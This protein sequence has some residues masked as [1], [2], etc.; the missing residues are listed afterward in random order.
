M[1]PKAEMFAPIERIVNKY[2]SDVNL[3]APAASPTALS[4][5]EDH[6]GR[7]LP[8]GLRDFLTR[9]NGATL[10][11]GA[12]R[13]RNASEFAA[14]NEASPQITL[15]AEGQ[16]NKQWA[17]ASDA[18]GHHVFGLWDG[19]R[20]RPMHATFKGWLA[21]TIAV[22]ET[23]VTREGD[24][25]SLRFA[26]D[27]S[28]IY[29]KMLEGE[30]HLA[31]GQADRAE[32]F[33][34]SA[35]HHPEGVVC[36]WQRLGDALAA[37]DRSAARKA[38]LTSFKN[39]RL[40]L[41]WPGAPCVE[42]HVFRSL[43]DAFSNVEDYERVLRRF[44]T[45]QVRDVTSETEAQLVFDAARTL[46]ASLLKRGHRGDAREVLSNL[47]GRTRSFSW[48]STPWRASVELAQLELELG[49]HD[50]AEALLRRLR[51]EGPHELQGKGLLLLAQIAIT[52]Q[53]PWAEEILADARRAGVQ[54]E[55]QV[56]LATLRVER[57]LR[58]ERIEEARKW[59]QVAKMEV[60]KLGKP[61]FEARVNLAEGDLARSSTEYEEALKHYRHGLSLLEMTDH[62]ETRFRLHL[63]IGDILQAQR[64]IPAAR[65]E[66]KI[67]VDGFGHNELPVREGWALVR[68][69]RLSE[70]PEPLLQA[71]KH[72]FERSDLAAGIAAVDTVAG[73]PGHSLDWHLNRATAQARARY[74]AQRSKPPW[75]RRDA[76]RPERRLGAHRLAIAACAESIV[77][78]LAQELDSCARAMGTGRTRPTDPP[79]MRYIAAVDLVAGHKSYS[80]AKLLLDHLVNQSVKGP[81]RRA[82]Q[83]AVARSPNA[84][85][86]DGLLRCI[87]NPSNYPAP[88]VAEA[89]EALGLRREIHATAA[90]L[91][92][93]APTGH[94]MSRKAAITALGRIGDRANVDLIADALSAPALEEAAALSLLML[95]DRRG[96]DFHA[97]ALTEHR[98]GLSGSPGE[99]VGRYGGP[100]H[101][102]LLRN[103]ANGADDGA[104]GAILG[105]GLLGDSRAIP[106]LLKALEH[107]DRKVSDVANGALQIITGHEEEMDQPGWK[108]RWNLWWEKH[109]QT[110]RPGV[111]YRNGVVYD[112]G[113]L[114][115]NMEH[116]DPWVRRT[117]YDELVITTGHAL[118][119][120]SEGPWRTQQGHLRAWQHW[121]REAK[122]WLHAGHWYLDGQT[123]T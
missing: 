57:A 75:E 6:L 94:P 61:L 107:R 49:N 104:L 99:I 2:K 98:T 56:I 35:T 15:F 66:F 84:A 44:L 83:G 86:V 76:E 64:Q 116:T 88:V 110:L 113:L 27:P 17:W 67:A 53:E 115:K 18:E 80:A 120:D 58:L 20:L 100:S 11:R 38:W 48:R 4:A 112:M 89:A 69:A 63:R 101:L 42:S 41:P 65:K 43:S 92:L 78:A 114:L 72:R 121:W 46:A 77:T 34:R 74:D 103:A 117:S 87:E 40:P 105:L 10:L 16:D 118:P 96:I 50:E 55:Q 111:R 106:V 54:K 73:M 22:T 85:L 93:A 9:Y 47:L 36:A 68:L 30:R 123:I 51:R 33:F 91:N 122:E 82:L 32:E 13:I 79:V 5:A 109:E 119:F 60:Q 8:D 1:S 23:R 39:T 90:L 7:R 21:G 81:A 95:G 12:L 37:S 108:S 45:D 52:R 28:D 24:K 70:K 25:D 19:A 97:R 62:P 71:A 31:K 3:L 14:A 102:L 59:L 26:A 29:Q